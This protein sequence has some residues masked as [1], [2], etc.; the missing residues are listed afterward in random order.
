MSSIPISQIVQ[1][2]PRVISA[3]GA[4]GA[5]DGLLLTQSPAV[6]PGTP[7]AFYSVADVAEYFGPTSDEARAAAVYFAGIIGGGQTPGSLTFSRYVVN[8]QGAAAYGGELTMSLSQLQALTG[9]LEVVTSTVHTATGVD[10]SAATSF[11]N[12]AELILAEFTAP[13]FTITYDPDRRRFVITTD[14]TGTT[15]T[16]D[17]VAGSLADELRLTP[18]TGGVYQHNG[19][20]ADTP[21]TAAQ[22]AADKA[23]GWAMFSTTWQPLEADR[24]AFAQWTSEQAFQYL[25][26]AYDD[27]QGDLTPNNPN[28]FGAQVHAVPYQGTI[29]VYGALAHAA[30]VMAWGASMNLRVVNGR[31]TLAFREPVAAITAQVD[32]LAAA[33]AL[34]SNHYTYLGRYA[35]SANT[36]T[37]F[38]NGEVSGQFEWADTY[39]GQVWLRRN[40][41]QALFET[42]KAYASL[43]YNAD[44]YNAL[45]Q[46]AQDVIGQAVAAGVIRGGVDL[47]PSQ[48]AQINTQAGVDIAGQV[49]DLGWFLQVTDPLTATVRTERGSPVINLWYCDGGSI[50]KL[51]VSSTTVL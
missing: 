42:L 1:I 46:G 5:L 48:R 33:N 23:S 3:G 16:L 41:Q 50:Q 6:P 14:A 39:L 12:A 49:A 32:T 4:Q 51:V 10:L 25:Y 44:G 37:V 19:A 26:V 20:D 13:D 8:A 27:D 28:A 11:A 2:N 45:Y 47:S 36:Y 35:S 38:Y 31:T 22:R 43:P 17:G 21:A 7:M 40:L 34:L 30:A 15:A 29:A 18:G 24:L 9:D